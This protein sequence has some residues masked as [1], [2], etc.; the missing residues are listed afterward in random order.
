MSEQRWHTTAIADCLTQA[1]AGEWGGE[2]NPANAVVL[3]AT[4]IDSDGHITGQGAQRAISPTKLKAKRLQDGDI[5]LEGSGGSP[6]NP[7]GR[8]ALFEAAKQNQPAL[9]SNFFKT[10]RP[11][12]EKVD[13]RFLWRKLCW[14]YRQP[15]LL[16]M[17]QQ[18][19]GI[20]N[21]KFH[22]YLAAQISLPFER[23]E[24]SKIAQVLDTLDTTI[25]Q[26]EAIIAKLK[27]VKQGLL[28]DLLTRGIDANGELRPPQSEAP[29]LY[30]ASP[31]GWIPLEWTAVELDHLVDR[32]R[33]IVYGILMPGQG[34]EG[35]VPVVKVK[36]IINGQIQEQGL[37]LTSPDIDREYR[38]SR[39][40]EGDLL[41][42]IRGTVGRTA[43][44]PG[45][46]RGA[47]ITQD[48]A[49][50]S[51]VGI[52][53]R[54]VREYLGMPVPSA[55]IATH[56]LGV[57]VQGINLRDVRRIPLAKPSADEAAMIGD[58]IDA[59]SDRLVEEEATAAKLALAKSGLM[60]DL[61]TGRVRVTPLLQD[62]AV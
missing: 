17:Q 1:F 42:T 9:C 14:F 28:Y 3:R 26:T 52:D 30:K 24:Q 12:H 47:N 33:P 22:D 60:D 11:N 44:V 62:Q 50:I 40:A 56:T 16:S 36:D 61:L 34:H 45:R 19:T 21:L 43:F 18:T 39:L 31:L 49:R 10:L 13:A 37:L 46:L 4:D 6:D 7:V 48:T 5:L 51:L 23:D 8:V 15:Q 29:H 54:F 20:I 58:R 32:Q 2:P 53:G 41:F 27:Q 38:R 59:I 25:R 55:F 57:A 35:G